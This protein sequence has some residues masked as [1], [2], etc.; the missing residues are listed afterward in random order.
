MQKQQERSNFINKQLRLERKVKTT[1]L[2]DAMREYHEVLG[3]KLLP[4]PQKPVLSDFYALSNGQQDR[5]LRFIALSMVGNGGVLWYFE[6]G[7]L[8]METTLLSR[9]H[10]CM[11]QPSNTYDQCP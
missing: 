5:E 1:E 7:M 9:D 11:K 6:D 4:L 3:H 2:N 10:V 8:L